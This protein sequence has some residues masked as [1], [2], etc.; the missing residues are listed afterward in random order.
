M[1]SV[2]WDTSAPR[3]GNIPENADYHL[4]RVDVKGQEAF[5]RRASYLCK[6]ATKVYGDRQHSFDASRV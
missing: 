1:P 4:T 5:F 6:V 2:R 3:A